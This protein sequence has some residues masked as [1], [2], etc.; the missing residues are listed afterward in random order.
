MAMAKPLPVLRTPGRDGTDRRPRP[1]ILPGGRAAPAVAEAR[2]VH[3]ALPSARGV[4]SN[5]RGAAARR[6]RGSGAPRR[7]QLG[8]PAP[9]RLQ[10]AGPA[11]EGGR[12]EGTGP[13]QRPA[14]ERPV[15]VRWR[16]LLPERGRLTIDP[17][18]RAAARASERLVGA[19]PCPGAQRERAP[20]ESSQLAAAKQSG[21]HWDSRRRLTRAG[22]CV[23]GGR[24]DPL[25]AQLRDPTGASVPAAES[26]RA[27]RAVRA[28]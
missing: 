19:V 5:A 26:Q 28:L 4:G 24:Q 9:V 18:Q 1:P 21:E 7:T 12:G 22:L 3:P 14:A 15:G 6:T 17:G 23:R 13:G 27:Q 11:A 20:P 16:V 2:C 10:G 8:Q 25:S